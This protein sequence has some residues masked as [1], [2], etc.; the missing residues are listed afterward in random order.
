MN[1]TQTSKTRTVATVL[2]TSNADVYTVPANYK[3]DVISICASNTV[4]ALRTFSLDWYESTTATWHTIAEA[5]ELDGNSLLQ[6]ENLLF[7]GQG[8]KLRALA[9]AASSVSLLLRVDEY[10]N[11]TQIS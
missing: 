9:S 5:V 7:L 3:T 10:F 2:G 1:T 8:D 4:S 11:P 6:I